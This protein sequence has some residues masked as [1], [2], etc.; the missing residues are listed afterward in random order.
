VSNPDG[1]DREARRASVE[2]VKELDSIQL[3]TTRD[4]EV[5]TRIAAYE[6]AFRMQA[7]VPELTDL[8]SEP[9]SVLDLYGVEPGKPPLAAHCLLARRVVEGGVRFVELYLR[10]WDTHGTSKNDDI[11]E[12]LQKQCRESDRPVAA[13]VRDLDQRG[14]LEHTLVVW[15]GEF[16]R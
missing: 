6:M 11:L 12:G 8:G 2:L 7:S 4:P 1:I 3:E 13:L 5:A 14:L 9:R 15:G 10:G 16:G